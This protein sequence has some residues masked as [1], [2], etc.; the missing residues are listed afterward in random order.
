MMKKLLSLAVLALLISLPAQAERLLTCGFEENNLI[1]TMWHSTSLGGGA[2]LTI[3]TT[4]VHSGTYSLRAENTGANGQAE[5]RRLDFPAMTSGSVFNR[6]YFRWNIRPTANDTI[7]YQ[8]SDGGGDAQRIFLRGSSNGSAVLILENPPSSSTQTGTQALT[9]DT[10]YRIELDTLLSDTVGQVVLRLYEADSTTALETLTINGGVDTLPTNIARMRWGAMEARTNYRFYFDDIAVNDS[11]G[12]FQ[13]TQA[14]PGKV[15]LLEPSGDNTVTWTKDGSAAEATNWEGVD[16][17]PGAP[18]DGVTYNSKT[19]NGTDK[20]DMTNLGAEV[21]SDADII[22]VDV[23]G[24]QG[25][26]GTAG[27]RVIDFELWDEADS[28]NTLLDVDADINGWV[29]CTPDEHLV[30]D[31]GSR[32]KANVDS[33]RVGYSRS[34]GGANEIRITAQWVNVEWIE[35][36][37]AP[38]FRPKVIV[39]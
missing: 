25:S 8:E 28:Q 3:V 26:N 6:F 37:A 33:F 14:G 27:T 23:Y 5:V 1:E 11:G 18:D 35:A 10:W 12:T 13:N 20:L 22:L 17:L 7:L 15:F 16:D 4:P 21:P 2:S 34:I 36:A 29:I 24:R 9:V 32:T 30:F 38:A 39:Y 19:S 31:A